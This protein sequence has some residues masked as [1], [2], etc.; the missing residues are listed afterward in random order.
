MPEKTRRVRMAELLSMG[1]MS[2]SALAR[3]F[4]ISEREVIEE[5]RHIQR[6]KKFGKLM[7]QPARCLKCGFVFRAELRRPKRCPKCHS[8]W[9]E[10]PRF[11]IER[12]G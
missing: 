8:T 12:N 4:E 5:L 11:V 2:L 9:I 7:V 6:S 1:P 3:E 10:E